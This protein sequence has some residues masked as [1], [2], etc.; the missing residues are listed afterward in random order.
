MF[1]L[2]FLFLFTFSYF[3]AVMVDDHLVAVFIQV[4]AMPVD[5]NMF[6]AVAESRFVAH[7]DQVRAI[8]AL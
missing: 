1:L 2:G 5:A 7:F 6:I 8:H 4:N 3:N